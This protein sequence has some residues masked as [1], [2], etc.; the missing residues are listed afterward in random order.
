MRKPL[1]FYR[2][3]LYYDYR[4]DAV[5]TQRDLT[6]AGIGVGAFDLAV[7]AWTYTQPRRLGVYVAQGLLLFA[8]TL[9][10]EVLVTTRR[11]PI[12]GIMV[13]RCAWHPRD[14]WWWP[15]VLPFITGFKL[16]PWSV[17]D[18]CCRKC[19]ARV[20]RQLARRR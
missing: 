20:K 7:L 18:G 12:D 15:R 14:V 4:G 16:G 8:L 11:G 5:L 19:A 13:V 9:I 17:T 10:V 2:G 1:P 3:M 6:L